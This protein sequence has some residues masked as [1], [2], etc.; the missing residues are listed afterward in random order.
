MNDD[1]SIPLYTPANIYDESVPYA[2]IFTQ[3]R[4]AQ[5]PHRWD[6]IQPSDFGPTWDYELENHITLWII[7]P[8]S[9]AALQWLY[10]HLHEHIARWGAK[11]FIVPAKDLNEVVKGMTRDKL[12][13]V[14]EYEQAQEENHALMQ[15]EGHD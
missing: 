13:S 2:G 11:G 14:D 3:T 1:T 10:C 5:G 9:E 15:G 6:T 7:T 4:A 8:I 12:M